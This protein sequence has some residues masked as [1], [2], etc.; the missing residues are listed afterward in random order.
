MAKNFNNGRGK[1]SSGRR[2][3]DSK[4][5][6]LYNTGMPGDNPFQTMYQATMGSAQKPARAQTAA[7]GKRNMSHTPAPKSTKMNEG[8]A[9]DTSKS[10]AKLAM[11]AKREQSRKF[12]AYHGEDGL[13]PGSGSQQIWQGNPCKYNLSC[14]HL[15]FRLLCSLWTPHWLPG[16]A[17][18]SLHR[19]FRS[20]SL[21]QGSIL[22]LPSELP[23]K[24]C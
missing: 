6:D 10:A 3:N 16:C 14:P 23:W 19:S 17:C 4:Q 9:Y 2:G 18:H 22:K 12:G 13:D 15:L 11:T 20:L 21:P 5:T 7:V 24:A 1:S 8:W